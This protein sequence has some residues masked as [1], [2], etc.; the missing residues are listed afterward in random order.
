MV[1]NLRRLRMASGMTQQ[2]LAEAANVPRICIARYEAGK[3][4][5]GMKNAGRLAVALGCRLDD[6]IGREDDATVPDHPTSG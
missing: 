5:P 3:Y 6:L 1:T 4:E 2:E